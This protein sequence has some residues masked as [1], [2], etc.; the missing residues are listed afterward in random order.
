MFDDL[1]ES[2]TV[3]K[4]TNTGWGMVVSALVQ[5]RYPGHPDLDPVDL[6]SGASEGVSYDFARCSAATS[7]STSSSAGDGESQA[8]RPFDPGQ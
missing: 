5:M 6:Y 7:A 8:N 4:K 2:T 3:R 1:V